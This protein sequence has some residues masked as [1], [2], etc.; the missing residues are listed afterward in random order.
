MTVLQSAEKTDDTRSYCIRAGQLIRRR[1]RDRLNECTM[2]NTSNDLPKIVT[3]DLSNTLFIGLYMTKNRKGMADRISSRLYHYSI[4]LLLATATVH[5][6][7]Q[8]SPIFPVAFV[9][10]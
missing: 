2:T 9:P 4:A 10:Q 7:I 5:C 1:Y 3:F 6:C 8:S